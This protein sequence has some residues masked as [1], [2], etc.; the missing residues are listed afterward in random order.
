MTTITEPWVLKW[1]TLVKEA[2]INTNINLVLDFDEYVEVEDAAYQKAQ[3]NMES[4]AKKFN[5]N[6]KKTGKL[7]R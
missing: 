5:D 6:F 1:R 7:E 3:I 2:K 4:K